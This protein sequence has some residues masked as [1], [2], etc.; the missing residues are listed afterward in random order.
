LRF[1]IL[2][3]RALLATSLVVAAPVAASAQTGRP[4]L[5]LHDS[6]DVLTVTF[7]GASQVSTTDLRGV[8]FTR[9]SPCRLVLVAPLCKVFPNNQLFIDRRRTTAA[10]LGEDLTTLRVYYWRRG[11]RDATVDTVIA[12]AKHGYVTVAFRVNEGEPTRVA[13]VA[14]AQ[15]TP[16]LTPQEL[17]HAQVL[18]AGDPLS[19]IALDTMLARLRDAVW[20]HGYGD[21]LIDTTVPRPDAS[22]LVPIRIAIDPR[23]LTRVG[24]VEFDGNHN[25]SDATLRRGV[26]LRP[27]S[28]YTR[29]AVLESERRLFESPAL[30]RALVITPPAGDSVKQITIDVTETPPHR[31]SLTLGFNT[32]EFGQAALQLRNHALGSGR[33]LDTRINVGNL[34]AEQLNG[35]AIFRQAIAPDAT[36]ASLFLRPTYQGSITLTQPWIAGP[37][38]SAAITL[39]GGRRS[40]PGV[41]VDDDIGA[42]IGVRRELAIRLPVGVNYRLEQT[43]VQGDAVYFCSGYGICDDATTSVLRRWQRLAPVGVSAWIDRSNDLEN[44]T[45]G[46]TAVVDAEHASRLTGSNFTHQRIT[47]DGSFYR[48]LGSYRESFDVLMQPKVLALHGRAGWVRPE[49]ILHPRARFY[50]GGMQSVRGFAENELGPQVLQARRGS[51]LAAGCTDATIADGSCNPAAVPSNELFTRPIGGSTLLEASAELRVPLG[52]LIGGVVFLD[53]GYVGTSGLDSPARGRGAVTPGVGL[54]Y[55]SPLGVLR[56]DF[57]LRPVGAQSLPV[58]VAVPDGA[59]GERIVRLTTE[60]SY[61]PIDPSPGALHSLARRIVVHFAMGQAF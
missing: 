49:G 52:R 29:D 6:M 43:R 12:P 5:A 34:L 10:A 2:L 28:L 57:G 16:V 46:Y 3:S 14:I 37:R 36:D 33:W 23:Y 53:G 58:V 55:R 1:T 32:I 35:H 45:R 27:G 21:A 22:R 18:R 51:L 54:R 26:L 40:L 60:K 25:L 8:I 47:A 15:R 59:G 56:M 50:A 41:V 44:P 4:K 19:L 11:Y 7:P 17:A 31:A 38:T 48:A 61:S 42:T 9:P 24:G 30:A 39:F 13:D 20:N